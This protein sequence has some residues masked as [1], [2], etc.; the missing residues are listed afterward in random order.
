[1]AYQMRIPNHIIRW[2]FIGI[3][4]ASVS[5][6]RGAELE[7]PYISKG[8]CPFEGCSYGKWPVVK[9]VTAYAEP[10]KSSSVVVVLH[11]GEQVEAVTGE[12]HVIPG[13]ARVVGKPHRSAKELDPSKEILILDYVGEGYSRVFQDGRFTSVKIARSKKRCRE[14]PN[15]RYCWVAVLQE[16]VSQWWVFVRTLDGNLEGWVSMEGGALR[17]IDRFS[18]VYGSGLEF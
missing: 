6:V 15:W 16:P 18:R 10:D 11:P 3:V 2:V 4:I 5:T 17:P 14:R 7:V 1:M 9:R 13:R 8:A 12:V